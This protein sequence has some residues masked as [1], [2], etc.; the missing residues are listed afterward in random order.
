MDPNRPPLHALQTVLPFCA[1][2]LPAGQSK[3]WATALL[4]AT[5]EKRPRG[6][7]LHICLPVHCWK[8]PAL[9]SAQ[10]ELPSV[11]AY[12][13][14][15]HGRHSSVQRPALAFACPAGQAMQVPPE[16][17][18]VPDRTE[19]AGQGSKSVQLIWP[20]ASENAPAACSL[21][22]AHCVCPT[23]GCAVPGG[24]GVH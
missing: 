6:Q 22:S 13:P 21:Q 10:R 5:A 4:A 16:T 3:Q 14:A 1:A 20:G 15:R 12:F 2:N 11:G 19:P 24:H 9:Q 18:D 23:M 7:L 8:V 17:L